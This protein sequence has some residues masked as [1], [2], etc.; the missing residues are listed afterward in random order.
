MPVSLVLTFAAVISGVTYIGTTY[1]GS[2]RQRYLF[3]PLTTALI[4]MLALILPEPVSSPYR[5]L[6]ALGILFSLGGDVFLM[7]PRDMFVWGLASFLV[8]HL[9]YI[10]AYVSRGGFQM[11][12]MILLP[13]ALYVAIFLSI[14]LPYAGA[15]KAPVILYAIVLTMMGWQATEL[16]WALRDG[17]ALLAMI[18]ALLFIASDSILALDKFRTPI[19]QR[20][21]LIMST[22]YAA[23]LGIAWSIHTFGA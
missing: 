21:L 7:A 11:H 6:I 23:L 17:S 20:D 22:Y 19:R 14:L 10:A 13:F 5:I 3:K 15:V 9:L 18:G 16:W 12:W 8:A 4:L 1:A 2:Q